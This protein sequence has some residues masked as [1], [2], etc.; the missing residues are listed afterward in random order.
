[1]AVLA[2]GRVRAAHGLCYPTSAAWS[3]GSDLL[4][5]LAG[6]GGRASFSSHLGNRTRTTS[7]GVTCARAIINPECH[8]PY[9]WRFPVT[10]TLAPQSVRALWR[11][12]REESPDRRRDGAGER[13]TRE[14]AWEKETQRNHRAGRKG[15]PRVCPQGVTTR[16]RA[17]SVSGC[18][19][20]CKASQGC[21]R[22]LLT[23]AV[24]WLSVRPSR[25]DRPA[26]VLTYPP[27][28]SP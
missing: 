5:A 8:W 26:A 6:F 12:D 11:D 1:M 16:P 4:L 3:G 18:K 19:Q 23:H 27:T 20:H 14:T 25:A 22:A 10:A 7:L 15:P 13:P 2:G 9:D 24:L 17:D 21:L 28:A